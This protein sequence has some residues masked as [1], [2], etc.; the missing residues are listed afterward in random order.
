MTSTLPVPARLKQVI[1]CL[2][3]TCDG[4][5]QVNRR[6][7][8]GVCSLISQVPGSGRDAFRAR[9]LTARRPRRPTPAA[10]TILRAVATAVVLERHTAGAP[11]AAGPRVVVSAAFRVLVARHRRA[12]RYVL[13]LTT[14]G[15]LR[16]TVPRSSSIA[17][18]VRF[19]ERQADWI[20]P[21]M[22]AQQAARRA[23][24]AGTTMW[25]RGVQVPLDVQADRILCGGS[26][27]RRAG[28]HGRAGRGGRPPAGPGHD[29]ARRHA[30]SNWR[31]RAASTSRAWPCAINA[32]AGAPVR[33]AA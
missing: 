33:S 1:T 15:A 9:N 25:M 22:A 20:R 2:Q 23:V 4:A 19:A 26:R 28:G 10:G 30:V 7:F 32:P 12:R 17:G 18:G 24:D 6:A 5:A 11:R 8:S 29:R 31:D 16:L 13:R 21:R 14:D 27:C 3:M